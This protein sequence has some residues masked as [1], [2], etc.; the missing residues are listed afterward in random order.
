VITQY[1]ESCSSVTVH[2]L[3][4]KKPLKRL[5]W[6]TDKVKAHVYVW[7]GYIPM[8]V[9]FILRQMIQ[10]WQ[11][12][13][14]TSSISKLELFNVYAIRPLTVMITFLWLHAVKDYQLFTKLY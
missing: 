4:N 5:D 3:G 6:Q 2:E 7:S 1:I 10:F 11:T 14:W 8:L 12:D 13:K 9:F